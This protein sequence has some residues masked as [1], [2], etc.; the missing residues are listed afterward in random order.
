MICVI[1]LKMIYIFLVFQ[2]LTIDFTMLLIFLHVASTLKFESFVC[3]YLC[4]MYCIVLFIACDEL[5]M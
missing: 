2:F 4:S 5:G 1:F 3:I